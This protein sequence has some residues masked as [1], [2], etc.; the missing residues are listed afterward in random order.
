MGMDGWKKV[1]LG[2]VISYIARG[3]TPKYTTE[4]EGM[5]VINQR[6]IRDFTLSL[7]NARYHALKKKNVTEEKRIK[8]Y[9]ILINST[10]V[11]TL[12]R[13]CQNFFESKNNLTVDSHVTI[14]RPN[15]EKIN[16]IYLGYALKE[17]QQKIESLGEGTTGQTELKR[18][19]LLSEI[20]IVYPENRVLQKKIAD[21]FLRVDEKIELN[22][23]INNNFF[24]LLLF[25]IMVSFIILFVIHLFRQTAIL[26][27]IISLF[28]L[29]FHSRYN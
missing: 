21:F 13:V 15:I 23:E 19:R 2:D 26:V 14:V 11:G 29:I 1:K 17:K 4:N 27:T 12:G 28:L 25:Y 20:D 16:P 18:E 22:N 5:T 6:C 3:I 7:E 10:G 8:K 9:D 24:N